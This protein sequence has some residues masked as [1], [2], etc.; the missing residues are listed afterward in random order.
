ML[1]D[2][3]LGS[4][5]ENAVSVSLPL[6]SSNLDKRDFAAALP[7]PTHFPLP[8]QNRDRPPMP[9]ANK[10]ALPSTHICDCPVPPERFPVSFLPHAPSVTPRSTT[11]LLSIGKC[12]V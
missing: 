9:G 11:V 1:S 8:P 2:Q 4:G 3:V 5:Q 10:A 7:P 12:P 6:G